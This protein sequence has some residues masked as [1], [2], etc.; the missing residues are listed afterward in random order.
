MPHHFTKNTI[1]ASFW[2]KKCAKD[3]LHRVDGGRRG[4][5]LACMGVKPSSRDV[6]TNIPPEIE[7]GELFK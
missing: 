1:Q 7:Q 5:C 2:C 6:Q 4:P 3:T